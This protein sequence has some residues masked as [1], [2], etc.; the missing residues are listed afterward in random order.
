MI[1]YTFIQHLPDALSKETYALYAFLFL[2]MCIL[3]ERT[4]EFALTT[5]LQKSFKY[6]KK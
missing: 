4:H 5:E 3:W 2:T 1:K 6:R